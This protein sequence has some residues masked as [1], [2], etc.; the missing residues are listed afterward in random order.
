MPNGILCRWIPLMN[1]GAEAV[2]AVGPA[3]WEGESLEAA[4]LA[5]KTKQVIAAA[6]PKV[7]M[8]RSYS[9]C[10]GGLSTGH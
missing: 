8:R 10:V 1:E 5:A 7:L 4:R 6:I 9:R 3:A 2:I